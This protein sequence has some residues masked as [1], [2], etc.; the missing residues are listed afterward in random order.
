[1]RTKNITVVAT[2]KTFRALENVDLYS[3]SPAWLFQ[4]LQWIENAEKGDEIALSYY[5]ETLNEHQLNKVMDDLDEI[6]LTFYR[7]I[8]QTVHYGKGE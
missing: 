7:V 5:V 8:T 2:V 1:M 3:D 6:G 4:L